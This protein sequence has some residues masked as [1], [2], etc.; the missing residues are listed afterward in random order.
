MNLIEQLDKCNSI[1]LL[2]N[3]LLLSINNKTIFND[4]EFMDNELYLNFF[5]NNNSVYYYNKSRLY[6]FDEDKFTIVFE[7]KDYDAIFQTNKNEFICYKNITKKENLL[8]YFYGKELKWEIL[9]TKFYKNISDN[10]FS[11]FE[12][13][14]RTK[15]SIYSKNN[16]EIWNYKLP[17]GFNI[18]LNIKPVN[19]ILYFTAY[20]EHQKNQLVSGLD[21]ET[22][23]VIWQHQYE[24]TSANKFISAP[25][26]NEKDQLFYG[27]GHIYQV[28]NPKTG[29]IVLEKIF[30]KCKNYNLLV[31][32][33]AVYD[34]K[35]WF[36]SGGGKNTKFGYVNIDTHQLE[37]I[38]NLPHEEYEVF[39]TPVFYEGKLYLRGKHQNSLYVFE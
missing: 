10:F 13:F 37:F 6:K 17:T 35:L 39:D 4:V 26:Y 28:F 36:V 30:D 29:E 11:V 22:G 31:D 19:N 12:R 34:N 2:Y 27:I 38:Q 3:Y 8:S 7:V 14:D 20:N 5:K 21:I 25:A 18:Y 16:I 23:K 32:A 24:V 15:F 33:Q 9:T 1:Q